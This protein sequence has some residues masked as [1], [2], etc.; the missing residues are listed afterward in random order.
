MFREVAIVYGTS[1]DSSLVTPSADPRRTD[2]KTPPGARVIVQQ[3]ME[4]RD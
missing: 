1:F 2:G 3:L 4:V